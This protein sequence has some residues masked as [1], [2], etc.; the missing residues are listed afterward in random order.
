[1]FL[2]NIVYFVSLRSWPYFLVRYWGGVI[3]KFFV[4]MRLP[5]LPS[6][7]GE[8]PPLATFF[9]AVHGGEFTVVE[10]QKFKIFGYFLAFCVYTQNF[11]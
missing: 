1:M 9:L 8:L 3:L 5:P 7:S 11:L 2:I 6:N 10:N 4:K